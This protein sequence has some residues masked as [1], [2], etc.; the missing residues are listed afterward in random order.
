M[1]QRALVQIVVA[2]VVAVFAV[3]IWSSGGRI[4][5][6]WLRYYSA[7]VFAVT[8]LILL[9]D[10]VIW[11][12]SFVQRTRLAS[13]DLS[14][15]WRGTL[16]SFWKD[17]STGKPPAPKLAYLA[18]RQTAST[19][20][21]ILLTDDSRSVSSL[22]TVSG[23]GGLASLDYIY[24]NRPDS[25]VE[26]RSH[27]HHGSTSLDIT[28]VPVTR[29]K[30]RYWTDRDSRG[31]LEFVERSNHTVEDYDEATRLFGGERGAA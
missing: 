20:S 30:G 16:T 15:T 12:L 9:W 26:H 10:R 29:L 25:K 14:G 2:V 21:V 3:G 13:R 8:A 28:G 31:E 19:V 4:E 11:K 18:V 1:K 6:G 7:A 23:G 27:M 5:L 24:L 22:G 17:P